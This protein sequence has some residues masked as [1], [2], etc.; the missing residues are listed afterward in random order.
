MYTAGHLIIDQHENEEP[1]ITWQ[2]M[3]DADFD[4]ENEE[5]P[6]FENQ[7]AKLDYN[8]TETTS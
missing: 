1:M 8:D 7:E 2:L 6:T 3:V 5:G 4:S